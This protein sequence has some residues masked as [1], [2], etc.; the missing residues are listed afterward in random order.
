SYVLEQ[1]S[2]QADLHI[3]L[4]DVC[5]GAGHID[6]IFPY[7][8]RHAKQIFPMLDCLDDLR[9]I[10]D[11]R[12]PNVCCRYPYARAIRR[13]IIFH[14]GPTNSDEVA[15]IDEIQMIKD[16][17]RGWAWTRALL[18]LCA[19]EIHVCGEAA[20]ID[21][22]TELMFTTGEEVEGGQVFDERSSHFWT[23]LDH[24]RRHLGS[25]TEIQPVSNTTS[26]IINLEPYLILTL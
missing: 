23:L 3:I 5:R 4:S 24:G 21:F 9:K 19:Q 20:A 2:L 14:A 13:K 10:S 8:M 11:L 12:S 26:E 7:F 16:P 17:M 15:V 22:I 18:G 25:V 6:D 1:S